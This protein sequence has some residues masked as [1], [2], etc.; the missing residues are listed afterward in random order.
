MIITFPAADNPDSKQ[1][2]GL[3]SDFLPKTHQTGSLNGGTEH[4][5]YS[6][7]LL[8]INGRETGGKERQSK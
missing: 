3:R 1:G 8:F 5:Y 2:T 7:I 6:I 4:F